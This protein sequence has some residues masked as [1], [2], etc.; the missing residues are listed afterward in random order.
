MTS[1][2]LLV[3]PNVLALQRRLDLDLLDLPA[4]ICL[5]EAAHAVQLAVAPWLAE[6]IE[7]DGAAGDEADGAAAGAA[8]TPPTD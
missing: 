2:I 6:Q 7:A 4:W 8:D 1:R 5:H 3:A